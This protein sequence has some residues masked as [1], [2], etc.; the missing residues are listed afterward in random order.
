MIGP[1]TN[2]LLGIFSF[3][4]AAHTRQ[5][6]ICNT[7]IT[8]GSRHLAEYVPNQSSIVNR[9]NYCKNC[10]DH[11]VIELQMEMNQVKLQ[12]KIL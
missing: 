1:T 5:C 3:E 8:A 9:H 4:V 12:M 7:I 6:N 10:G 2:T 11:K